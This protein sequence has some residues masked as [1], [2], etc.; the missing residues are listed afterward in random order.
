MDAMLRAIAEPNRRRILHMVWDGEKAAG[1]IA[2]GF[3]VSRPAISQHL[4]VL[5][6]AGLVAV[7]RAGTRRLYRARPEA[8]AA[9]MAFLD[10]FWRD[11]LDRLKHAA[12]AEQRRLDHGGQDRD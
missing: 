6:D 5:E 1:D 7:R 2:A 11:G 12:E 9:L 4:R 10:S 8:V 3:A